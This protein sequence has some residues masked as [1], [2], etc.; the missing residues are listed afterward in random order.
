MPKDHNQLIFTTPEQLDEVVKEMENKTKIPGRIVAMSESDLYLTIATGTQVYEISY[1]E[2]K[3]P[4]L[5]FDIT[6]YQDKPTEEELE[7]IKVQK[8]LLKDAKKLLEVFV[9][10]QIYGKDEKRADIAD[11]IAAIAELYKM[12]EREEGKSWDQ[13]IAK[14]DPNLPPL[15]ACL[16]KPETG[17]TKG[18]A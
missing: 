15:H 2:G 8:K 16:I 18:S 1:R 7:D 17:T 14:P 13:P 11:I 6:D 4:R 10:R 3:P 9:E 12:D 5:I